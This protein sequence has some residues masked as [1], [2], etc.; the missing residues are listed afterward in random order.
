MAETAVETRAM[1][2]EYFHEIPG[3]GYGNIM[4]PGRYPMRG[5]KFRADHPASP[6][7]GFND[8][9]DFQ[10]GATGEMP[11]FRERGY[12]ASCFP[13]GDGITMKCLAGQDA[14]KVASDIA[15]VF[16]WVVAVK[17]A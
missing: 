10:C 16:G 3:V 1:H 8:A 2:V 15:D 6:L 7:G 11:Q 17:R 14:A 5:G 12:W 9:P 13:E 4:W